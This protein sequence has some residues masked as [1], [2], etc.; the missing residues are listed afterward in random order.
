MWDIKGFKL[1]SLNVRSLLP[2]IDEVR[3]YMNGFDIICIC[4]TWLSNAVPNELVN[5]PGYVIFSQDRN[6]VTG[7]ANVSKRGGGLCIYVCD[8]FAKYTEVDVR[9]SNVSNDI[10]QLWISIKCPNVKYKYIGMIYRPPSGDIDMCINDIRSSLE[11]M[12][13]F[14]SEFIVCDDFNINYNLRHTDSF[15]KL[16]EFE[17]DFIMSQIINVD[18]RITLRTSTRIDLIFTNCCD[19]INSGTIESSISDHEIIYFIKKKIKIKSEH[20]T[21]KARTFQNYI[22][23]NFQQDIKFDSRWD[24][25]WQIHNVDDLWNI[26]ESIIS[27][28]SDTHCPIKDIR[29]RVIARTGLIVNCSKRFITEIAFINKLNYQKLRKIG[30]YLKI[31]ERK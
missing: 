17:R 28:H 11:T 25:F 27:T 18:T 12:Y 6:I 20:T 24:Y 2:K 15:Q 29:I 9:I 19:I 4:E 8:K 16:K 13:N 1:C 5:I 3:H 26:F 22:K 7:N 21:I 30:Y 10:E 31:K 23:E 14:T